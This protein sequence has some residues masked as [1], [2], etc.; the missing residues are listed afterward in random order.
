MKIFSR[1]KFIEKYN[2]P[3]PLIQLSIYTWVLEC[4]GKT[5]EEM[6]KMGYLTKEDWFVEKED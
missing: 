6:E 4:D 3:S 2:S 1:E 5:K